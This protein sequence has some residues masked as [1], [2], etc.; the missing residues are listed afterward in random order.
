MDK[1]HKEEYCGPEVFIIKTKMDSSV[2]TASFEGNNEQPVIGGDI[3]E[4]E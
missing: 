1:T 3:G 2:L 4:D